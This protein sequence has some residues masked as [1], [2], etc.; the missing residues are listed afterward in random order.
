MIYR[1]SELGPTPV[2]SDPFPWS[3]V[4]AGFLITLLS[5]GALCF[6]LL[7]HRAEL[8]SLTPKIED[9]RK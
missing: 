3:Y 9:H 5:V 8:P 1:D 7:S 2:R 4:L 6:S